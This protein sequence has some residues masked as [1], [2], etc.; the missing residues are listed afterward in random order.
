MAKVGV[1]N[2]VDSGA[3]RIDS[4]DRVTQNNNYARDAQ[5]HNMQA[6]FAKTASSPSLGL[7]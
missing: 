1:W 7:G 6:A 3:A 2:G 4:A 5:R